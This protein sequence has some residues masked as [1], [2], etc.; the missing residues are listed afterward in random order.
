MTETTTNPNIGTMQIKS[1]TVESVDDTGKGLAKLGS[2]SAIDRDNDTY[3]PGAFSWDTQW[4]SMLPAHNRSKMP[5]GKA[6]VY[7]DGDTIYAEFQLNLETEAGREWHAALKFDLAT[8][9]PVQEWS[10]GYSTL[11]AE[12]RISA[13]AERVR[14]LKKVKVHEVSPVLRAAGL[15]TGTMQIKSAALKDGRFNPLLAD[16]AEMAT[17][18]DGDASLLSASGVKQVSDIHA[19]LGAVLVK[20]HPDSQEDSF[21]DGGGHVAAH[22]HHMAQKH[23]RPNSEQ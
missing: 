22:L 12:F 1:M 17:V 11:D 7:E 10:Y 2:L 3:M 14:V 21:E 23:F 15:G 20:T 9:N 18:L 5:F 19:A 6:R 8:G 13:G 4:A 16:L